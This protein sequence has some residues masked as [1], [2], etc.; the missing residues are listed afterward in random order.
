[1]NDVEARFAR[2]EFDHRLLTLLLFGDLFRFD[3]DAGEFGKFLDVLLQIVAARALGEDHLEL[4]AGMFLPL[5]LG[6]RRQSG[7]AQRADCRRTGQKAA[8]RDQI[9][10]H[11]RFSPWSAFYEANTS[12][13]GRPA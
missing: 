5:H 13:R 2:S 8:A 11:C 12:A 10:R 3:L 6:A 7:E 1:V 4:G 9:I